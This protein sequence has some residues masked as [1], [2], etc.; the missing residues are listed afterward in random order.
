MIQR[1]PE[2]NLIMNY[3]KNFVG[4]TDANAL[5]LHK[6]EMLVLKRYVELLESNLLELQSDL[7]AVYNSTY[8]NDDVNGKHF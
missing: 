6:Q 7:R 3:L 5:D 2:V 4:D 1:P 8:R